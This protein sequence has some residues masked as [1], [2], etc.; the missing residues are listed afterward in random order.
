MPQGRPE[1]PRLPALLGLTAGNGI[2]RNNKLYLI[3]F[4]TRSTSIRRSE[5][6]L[7]NILHPYLRHS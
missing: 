2:L 1:N 6:S 5:G 3:S 7:R 4:R